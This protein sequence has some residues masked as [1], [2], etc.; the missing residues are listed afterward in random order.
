MCDWG[1]LSIYSYY[2]YQCCHIYNKLFQIERVAA[3]E[4][5]HR[6]INWTSEGWTTKVDPKKR[7]RRIC[8]GEK[9]IGGQYLGV[10]LSVLRLIFFNK[11][12]K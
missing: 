5:W 12:G 1:S 2:I 3:R 8:L 4:T 10:C 7:S 6:W 11:F 9:M